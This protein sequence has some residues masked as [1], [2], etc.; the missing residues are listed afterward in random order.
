MRPNGLRCGQ[1]GVE[2]VG[3]CGLFQQGVEAPVQ[4][5][6]SLRGAANDEPRVPKTGS[7][8]VLT[9]AS[10]RSHT[11]SGDD[12][13]PVRLSCASDL[14][15]R[16]ERRLD[17]AVFDGLPHRRFNDAGQAFAVVEH[18]IG[19]G[20]KRFVPVPGGQVEVFMRDGTAVA[21]Q[22]S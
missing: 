8:R 18:A 14:G 3:R 13:T 7:R 21:M 9:L 10:G 20:P 2:I 6:F 16:F 22:S 17:A 1:C 12:E 15:A 5:L 4:A 11:A 19:N